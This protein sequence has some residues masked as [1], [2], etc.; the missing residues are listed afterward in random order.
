M[1]KKS[2]KGKADVYQ[3]KVT[4]NGTKPPI[5]RRILVTADTRLSK[6]HDILQDVMGWD[7]QHLHQFEIKG[8]NYGIP[9]AGFEM[10]TK[11]EKSKTLGEVAPSE[12]VKFVYE[13]DFGDSWEHAILVE[14][15]MEPE[16]GKKYPV[17]IDGKL[18]CPPEDCGGVW[19]YYDTVEALADPEHPEHAE[20]LEWIGEDFDPEYF[21]I[22]SVN[23]RLK[24]Y[25]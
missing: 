5:W 21:D 8:E 22:D 24:R 19:G 7:D 14:K 17:C 10:G 11:N 20:R 18:A 23:A 13:Y 15:I 3:L 2:Q 1:P 6:L 12:K 25:K 4:L 9:S 16:E